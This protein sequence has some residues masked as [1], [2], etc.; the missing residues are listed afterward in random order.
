MLFVAVAVPLSSSCP[1]YVQMMQNMGLSEGQDVQL[2]L[3]ELPLATALVLQP[4]KWTFAEIATPKIASVQ[5]PY[6]E[7]LDAAA[8]AK[9]PI[10]HRSLCFGLLL[11]MAALPVWSMPWRHSLP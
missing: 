11:S 3:K 5:L 10:A 7:V 2:K 6:C 8:C 9:L 1:Y 4:L